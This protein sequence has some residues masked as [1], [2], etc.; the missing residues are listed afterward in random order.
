MSGGVDSAVAAS[1][2]KRA[3]WEV[4]GVTL[5]LWSDPACTDPRTARTAEAQERAASVAQRVGVPHLVVD[6]EHEFYQTVVRYFVDEYASGRTPNPCCKCNAR[7]RFRLFACL[8]RSL[9]LKW[10]ATGHYARMIGDPPGLARAVDRRKDQSY[11]LAEVSPE[12]LER[13]LFPLGE[14]HKSQVRAYAEE[15]GLADLVSRDSQEI[16]FVPDDDYR[17]FLR[18]HL[19][20]RPGPIVDRRGQVLGW[21]RAVYDYTIGQR[22][23]LGLCSAGTPLY[24]VEILP[25]KATV[26]VGEA[27]EALV[28]EVRLGNVVCHRAA[29]QGLVEAQLR[30][31]GEAAP[32]VLKDLDWL[33]LCQPI[34]G[35]APGQT[36]VVYQQDLVILAGTIL[37]ASP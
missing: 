27:D 29:Q 16:C 33:M 8:A 25:E 14:L 34:R 37:S 9:G 17:R 23:G 12:L 36:A 1:L 35:V 20:E 32:A 18:G 22:R 28:Q 26:V 2:L 5:R 24:V 13:C 11:V 30:S 15:C 6:V 3:G 19:E 31:S 10:V 4:V 21:H 7:F